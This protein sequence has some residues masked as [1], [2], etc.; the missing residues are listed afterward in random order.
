V[1]GGSNKNERA[2]RALLE[3]LNEYLTDARAIVTS[4][5]DH[6]PVRFE[7]L[8]G[9]ELP[10]LLEEAGTRRASSASMSASPPSKAAQRRASATFTKSPFRPKKSPK[11]DLR[12]ERFSALGVIS[13]VLTKLVCCAL[14]FPLALSSPKTDSA[15]SLYFALPLGESKIGREDY[16]PMPISHGEHLMDIWSAPAVSSM[17]RFP[18]RGNGRSIWPT[19]RKTT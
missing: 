19:T 1:T 18:S 17:G 14:V 9:S 13:E 5:P 4:L 8:P 7:V 6:S 3:M 2:Q 12:L 11:T 15:R 16:V 10:K